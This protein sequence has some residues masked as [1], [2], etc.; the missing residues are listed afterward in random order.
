MRYA[1][2]GTTGGGDE[3]AV[4]L[5]FPSRMTGASRPYLVNMDQWS[6]WDPASGTSGMKR[7]AFISRTGGSLSVRK[8]RL[9]C[10]ARSPR[11]QDQ[12][13]RSRRVIDGGA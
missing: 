5:T 2:A 7:K 9:A 4:T 11:Q 1:N 10:A 12:I 13:C 6:Q 3:G 8:V